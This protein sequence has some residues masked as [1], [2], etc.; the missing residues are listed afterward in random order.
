MSIDKRKDLGTKLINELMVDIIGALIPGFLFVIVVFV[1][2]VIPCLIYCE[3]SEINQIAQFTGGGFWWVV[4]IICV[5]FSYV[6]GHVCYRADIANPDKLDVDKQI[7]RFVNKVKRNHYDEAALK[8]LLY[9]EIKILNQRI[10][11]GLKGEQWRCGRIDFSTHLSDACKNAMMKL[12]NGMMPRDCNDADFLTILFPEDTI[13]MGNDITYSKLSQGSKDVII[14]YEKYFGSSKVEMKYMLIIYCILHC[15]MD[16]GCATSIRCDFPYT[17][18]YKYLL[19][20]NMGEL[21]EHVNWFTIEDRSKNK[22]NSL[23][24]KIQIF[25]NEAYA[26][27]NKNESH[28]R[29]SSSTW[30]ITKILLVVTGVSFFVFSVKAFIMIIDSGV[31]ANMTQYIA[32]VLPLSMLL[33]VA[34][35]RSH[36]VKYIHYQR[37]REIQYTLQIYH[38]FKSIIDFRQQFYSSHDGR[39]HH[40]KMSRM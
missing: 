16:I 29:M 15:Q 14:E 18:Y 37:M 33:L 17:N 25:A 21:L 22:I 39:W 24:I 13:L 36:V 10:S 38:Q 6:V 3:P 31:L 26:L 4:L 32:F 35:I 2:A 19:K 7:K 12:D 40:E 11:L 30:H 27:I 28:I 23:K 1:S 20:R 8:T 5:I 34:Y 9:H